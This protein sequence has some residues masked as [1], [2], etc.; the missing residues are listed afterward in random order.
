[1][2]QASDVLLEDVP[3]EDVL[4]SGA[5]NVRGD[6]KPPSEIV[7]TVSAVDFASNSR[8]FTLHSVLV[9][10]SRQVAVNAPGFD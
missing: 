10:R 9:T 2:L 3:L 6:G 7:M 8:P 1:M 5:E 4:L